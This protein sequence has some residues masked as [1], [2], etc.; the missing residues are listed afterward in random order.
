M[1]LSIDIDEV[2]AVLLADGWHEVADNDEGVSSFDLD[3]YEFIWRT[4]EDRDALT[5]HGG[6]QS[7][8]CATGFIFAEKGKRK[9]MLCGPLTAI[10]AVRTVRRKKKK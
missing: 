7:E 1:S 9:G 5:L 3:A 4:R 6:G 2:A 10:L 8:V